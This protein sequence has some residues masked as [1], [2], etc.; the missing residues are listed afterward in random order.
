MFGKAYVLALM[1]ERLQFWECTRL[2][3]N[4]SCAQCEAE[5]RSALI[6]LLHDQLLH[7]T[8]VS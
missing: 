1:H 6:T 4:C 2:C 3:L 7:C 8:A 5:G